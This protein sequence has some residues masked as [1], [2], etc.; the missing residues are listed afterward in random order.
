MDLSC[1]EMGN[2]TRWSKLGWRED[3]GSKARAAVD[4][5]LLLGQGSYL[6]RLRQT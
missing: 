5:K 1:T 3:P 2:A 6:N 4:E